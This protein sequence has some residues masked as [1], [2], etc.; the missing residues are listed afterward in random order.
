LLGGIA[1]RQHVKSILRDEQVA[2]IREDS[3]AARESVNTGVP[4][5]LSGHRSK[6]SKDVTQ[7]TS[8]IAALQPTPRESSAAARPQAA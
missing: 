4:V 3:Y 1:R 8:L 6:L 7:L 5:S 2:Y